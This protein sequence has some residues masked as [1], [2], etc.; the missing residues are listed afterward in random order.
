MTTVTDKPEASALARYMLEHSDS[1]TTLLHSTVAV[2]DAAGRQ[3]I[4]L[5]DGTRDHAALVRGMFESAVL[6]EQQPD[7]TTRW[8]VAQEC[9]RGGL[10]E[11]VK[12]ALM[13]R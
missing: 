11:L 13:S 5:C 8:N 9:V 10:A 1:V 12:L 2:G 3:L 6:R 7:D 4:A